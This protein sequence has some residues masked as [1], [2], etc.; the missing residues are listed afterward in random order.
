MNKRQ[1]IFLGLMIVLLYLSFKI[2]NF[3][4]RKYKISTYISQQMLVIEEIKKYLE[5][6]NETIEYI[7]TRSFKN[8]VLKED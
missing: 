8:K 5:V 7:N 2:V 4:Y 6:A 3:E 1:Y